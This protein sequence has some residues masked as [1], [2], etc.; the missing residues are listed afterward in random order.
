MS[1]TDRTGGEEPREGENDTSPQ[2]V[3]AISVL[4]VSVSLRAPMVGGGGAKI[5]Y[6]NHDLGLVGI[7]METPITFTLGDKESEE[8]AIRIM[9][10]T[11]DVVARAVVMAF[12]RQVD[13]QV[14]YDPTRP[15]PPASL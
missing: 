1:N 10:G 12:Q 15:S 13:R 11:L 8:Q 3:V 2:H 14:R 7:P 9:A 6:S 5:A 4:P